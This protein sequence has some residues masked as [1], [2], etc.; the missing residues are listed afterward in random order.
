MG[1]HMRLNYEISPDDFKK[2]MMM[3]LGR[4]H[5]ILENASDINA[6]KDVV[7]YGCLN[8]L[9]YDVQIEGTRFNYVYDL[10]KYFNDDQ[11]FENQVISKFSI[12]L[13]YST[14]CHLCDM[15]SLFYTENKSE[16]SKNTLEEKY[17]EFLNQEVF[18]YD[19]KLKLVYLCVC[20]KYTHGIKMVRKICV[21]IDLLIGNKVIL[22]DDLGWFFSTI[23]ES[24]KSI[25]TF[26]NKKCSNYTS[27]DI[28]NM[29]NAENRD[30]ELKRLLNADFL[31]S[32]MKQ[33]DWKVHKS[34]WFARIASDEEKLKLVNYLNQE[35]NE[36]VKGQMLQI[37]SKGKF[38]ITFDYLSNLYKES[39]DYLKHFILKAILNLDEEE[40]K[41]F[42]YSLL[43]DENFRSFGLKMIFKFYNNEDRD[44]LLKY[45]PKVTVSYD[46]KY[47]W[48][49][50]YLAVLNLIDDKEH[51]APLELLT[52]MYE[53]S[54]C[55]FCR[56]NYLVMMKKFNV[57]LKNIIEE[58]LYDSNFDIRK[59]ANKS[60]KKSTK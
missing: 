53:N 25:T 31:I 28:D 44:I 27:N 14:F 3:G 59:F 5:I 39:S 50:L 6:F 33:E 9:S 38:P 24:Y 46:D 57:L 13:N 52:V 29:S 15:L 54:L 30:E 51:D 43:E 10:I 17:M 60:I 32:I 4:T 26:I 19:D 56:E 23:L 42:G 16:L 2:Y 22:V 11:F 41:H 49:S 47:D 21:D 40:I 1:D 34:L 8:N 36:V 45:V 48:H 37:I 35:S 18:D 7:L 20:L 58:C 12:M 55:S